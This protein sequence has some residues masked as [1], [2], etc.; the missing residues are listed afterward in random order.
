MNYTN[1][2]AIYTLDLETSLHRAYLIN[3]YNHLNNN[4]FINTNLLSDGFL[5]INP[6]DKWVVNPIKCDTLMPLNEIQ[7]NGELSINFLIS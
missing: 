6:K 5:Q 1:E 7:N 4:E 2:R 3:N